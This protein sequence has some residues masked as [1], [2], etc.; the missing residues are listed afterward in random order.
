MTDPPLDR[1]YRA[2]FG[3]PSLWR[4]LLGGTIARTAQ[5]M[6]AIALVLFTLDYYGS[7]A[8]AG[9]VTFASVFPGLLVS[10]IAGALLDRHGRARLIVL[11]YLVCAA[12]FALIAVLAIVGALPAWLLIAIATVSSMTGIF[13]HTGLRSMFPIIVPSHLWERVNAVDSNGYLVAILV[14]PP[15]AGGLVQV[16]GGPAAI[17]IIACVYA[18]GALVMV[19]IPDPRPQIES[20]GRLLVDAWQGVLYTWRNPV[21]RALGF[22]ISTINLTNGALTLLVPIL[23]IDRLGGSPLT[24]GLVFAIQGVAGIAAAFIVG[25]WRTAGRERDMIVRPM[26]AT[27]GCLLLL[28]V[29]LGLPAVL[30]C[31]ALI[32]FLN[33]PL[34]VAMFTLRQRRTD[35]AWMGRAFAVSMA[36]NFLGFP[37]GSAVGGLLVETSLELA[38]G[39]AIA[40]AGVAAVVSW[41]IIPRDQEP[42]AG[43]DE[44]PS[45][46]SVPS[47]E[48]SEA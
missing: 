21:L 40:A 17:G 11:D 45:A 7:P 36:F 12:A 24:V 46:A 19:G 34:D 18:L 1:S 20:T 4:I 25:R 39:F 27:A 35:P 14:G 47:A 22:S 6:V 3:V 31:F 28:T 44:E 43:G 2:L 8:L 26:A 38:I 10:P 30:V 15:V 41:A 29:P 16:L 9:V 37:I 23:V 5:S 13:S 48:P 33:G 42:V 32:G